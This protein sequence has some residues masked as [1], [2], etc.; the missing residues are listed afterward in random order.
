M[1]D[2][3]FSRSLLLFLLIGL[4]P[5]HPLTI[6]FIG[7]LSCPKELQTSGCSVSHYSSLA[8]HLGVHDGRQD[9]G[10]SK[11]LIDVVFNDFTTTNDLY[12]KTLET[13]L[14]ESTRSS[15]IVGFDD[16]CT[17]LAALGSAF[18]ILT[19]A[20]SC[21]APIGDTVPSMPTFIQTK[22]T[23]KTRYFALAQLL[24]DFNWTNVA[25]VHLRSSRSDEEIRLVNLLSALRARN[26]VCSVIKQNIASKPVVSFAGILAS[27]VLESAPSTRIYILLDD[28]GDIVPMFMDTLYRFGLL[29]TGE[30]FVFALTANEFLESV[31][32]VSLGRIYRSPTYKGNIRMVPDY[33]V[34]EQLRSYALFVDPPSPTRNEN[35]EWTNFVER[36]TRLLHDSP[37]SSS[38]NGLSQTEDTDRYESNGNIS[39]DTIE[40]SSLVQA[41]DMGRMLVPTLSEIVEEG[42]DTKNG[43]FLALAL[44]KKR[45]KSILNYWTNLDEEGVLRHRFFLLTPKSPL[46]KS[47]TANYREVFN[48]AASVY[49]GSHNQWISTIED[50]S[51][52]NLM[53]HGWPSSKLGCASG[54]GACPLSN[55][56]NHESLH[57]GVLVIAFL[58]AT[59]ILVAIFFLSRKIQ[60]ERRLESEY[61]V[62]P[63]SKVEL[64]CTKNRPKSVCSVWGARCNDDENARVKAMLHEE[65]WNSI[66]SWAM[67]CFDGKIVVVRRIFLDHL[68]LTR[69]IRREIDALMMTKHENLNPFLGLIHEPL[70]I[71]TIHLYCVRNSLNGLLRNRELSFDRL[72][73]VSFVEDILRGMRYLHLQSVIGYHGNLKST[74]CFVDNAWRIKLSNFGMEQIRCGENESKHCKDLLWTAPE[75]L[76]RISPRG[77]MSVVE[78]TRA[79]LYSLGIV[80]YEIYGRE[81]PFGDDLLDA[82]EIIENIKYPNGRNIRPDLG[83]LKRSTPDCVLSVIRN[84]WAEKPELRP[85]IREVRERLREIKMG[86][87]TNIADNMMELL[88]RYQSNLEDIIRERITAIEEERKRNDDLLHQLL[89]PPVAKCLKE[90]KPVEAENFSS[91]TVYFSDIVGFTA[92]SASSTPMEVV[93]MLNDLYSLFDTLI[94]DYDC[95]KVETIGD[96]YMFVSGLPHQNGILHAGEV[97][98][99]ACEILKSIL[100]FRI[101]HKPDDHL[102]LRIGIHTGP[103]V[104]GVVGV[105]MPRYCLFGDTVFTASRME[106]SGKPMK[107]QI[108]ETTQELLKELGGYNVEQSDDERSRESATG[109]AYWLLG[110]NPQMR[111]ERVRRNINMFSHLRRLV[112]SREDS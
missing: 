3:A 50:A 20:V 90:G 45:F 48:I 57:V 110:Y 52:L 42:G 92:L 102:R 93:N 105:R 63:S 98:S 96:A 41:Y 73:K 107:I 21:D 31:W 15:V 35:M 5:L 56:G 81:G 4:A 76:R 39:Y 17:D 34:A 54:G 106:S 51:K 59:I 26:I 2:N 61:F 97:S 103:V 111:I 6:S 89:P 46:P 8:F 70:Q 82:E 66:G 19:I 37:S 104:A 29:Q 77:H 71:F 7:Q 88:D 33:V 91:V 1:R 36:F 86:L 55:K 65:E 30:Y 84:C 32:L 112:K 83:I 40:W 24:V 94:S 18:N 60:Y 49:P 53:R 100:D 95:Y 38:F 13:F 78:L 22:S 69:E 80:L 12:K 43:T 10:K 58:T 28:R 99:V 25:V 72:F 64:K 108:S 109:S 79:D 75:V 23:E 14:N 11:Q 87:R 67:A 47:Y 16:S 68:K 27:I 101:H 85:G 9:Y 74:N 44:R 62:I